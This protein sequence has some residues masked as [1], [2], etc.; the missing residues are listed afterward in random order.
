MK[1]I[2]YAFKPKNAIIWIDNLNYLSSNKKN[3]YHFT[4]NSQWNNIEASYD[5]SI[6]TFFLLDIWRPYITFNMSISS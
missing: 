1:P 3:N 5:V 4:E 6:V 2:L